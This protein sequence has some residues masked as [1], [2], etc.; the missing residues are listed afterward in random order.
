M[1]ATPHTDRLVSLVQQQDWPALDALL[2]RLT[3]TEF[4]R[5]ERTLRD[6]V[7]PRFDADHFWPAYLHLIIY[8]RQAFLSCIRATARLA[9]EQALPFDTEAARQVAQQ[10]DE[11]NALK[12]IDMALPLLQTEEQIDALF[13]LFHI[14]DEQRRV[15]LLIRIDTPLAYYIL[16]R[17]L[18]HIPDNRPLAL[19]CYR[20][21]LRRQNDRAFNMASILRT[22]FGLH[23]AC[24]QLSLHIEPYELS[25]LDRSFEQFCYVLDGKRPKV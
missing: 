9:A 6:E 2:D 15:A 13:A 23:E 16:F 18:C 19:R 14:D 5:T 21:I 3:H 7:L 4:R 11:P 1:T 22:Y 20:Y 12:L 10:L 24:G 8:K 17:T 25:Y